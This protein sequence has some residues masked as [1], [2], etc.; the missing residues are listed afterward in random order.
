MPEDNHR[1]AYVFVS[2][3]SDDRARV[4]PLIEALTAR[5]IPIWWDG[6]IDPGSPWRNVIQYKR[7]N[8]ACVLVFW[9]HASVGSEWVREEADVPKRLTRIVLVQVV[10]DPDANIPMG[11]A[12]N[13]TRC[14]PP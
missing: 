6:R 7:D 5:G 11:H 8:A 14:D 2:Y 3:A 1:P 4:L 13:S 9:T 10:L 12:D